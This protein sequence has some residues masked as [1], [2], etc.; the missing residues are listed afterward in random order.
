LNKEHKCWFL[1]QNFQPHLQLCSK[2]FVPKPIITKMPRKKWRGK[3]GKRNFAYN[4][5][6]LDLDFVMVD[7]QLL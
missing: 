5:V 7:H 1:Q 3:G 4:L 2:S 6:V